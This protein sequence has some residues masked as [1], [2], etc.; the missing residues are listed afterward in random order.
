MKMDTQTLAHVAVSVLDNGNKTFPCAGN[1]ETADHCKWI[2]ETQ[3][4][5][6]IKGIYTQ[7]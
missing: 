6:G 4:E 5:I 1:V 2:N 3:A 7:I